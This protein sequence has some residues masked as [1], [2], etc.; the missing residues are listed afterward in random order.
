M[1]CSKRPDGPAP[2]KTETLKRQRHTLEGGGQRRAYAEDL[3]AISAALSI[4]PGGLSDPA[5]QPQS[6]SLGKFIVNNPFLQTL[7]VSI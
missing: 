7:Y 6:Q 3:A 5:P 1:T 4:A 2:D